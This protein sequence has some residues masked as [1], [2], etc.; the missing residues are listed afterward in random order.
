MLLAEKLLVPGWGEIGCRH[1]VTISCCTDLLYQEKK[2]CIRK[3]FLT[4]KWLKILFWGDDVKWGV[5][6]AWLFISLPGCPLRCPLLPVTV[7][8]GTLSGQ[9]R[10]E[11]TINAAPPVATVSTLTPAVAIWAAITV[12][13]GGMSRRCAEI[14][15]LLSLGQHWKCIQNS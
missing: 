3:S 5:G 8:S 2:S 10:V 9:D 12:I 11:D 6:R 15:P 4:R 14:W 13:N 7:K 1:K